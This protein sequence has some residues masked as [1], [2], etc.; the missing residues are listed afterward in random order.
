MMNLCNR[1][2]ERQAS[3]FGSKRMVKYLNTEANLS[4]P[5][6]V[7]LS[8]SLNLPCQPSCQALLQNYFEQN[9]IVFS[10]LLGKKTPQ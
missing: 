8:L 2:F 5:K 4:K 6:G 1:R 9:K 7:C 10:P 3:P